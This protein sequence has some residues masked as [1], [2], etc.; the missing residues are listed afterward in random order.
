M[1]KFILTVLATLVGGNAAAEWVKIGETE[2]S[3]TYVEPTT[4]IRAG[5]LARMWRMVDLRKEFSIGTDKPFMSS[6]GQDEYD[7]KGE[8]ARV[9]TLS[10]HSENMGAGDVVHFEA[11]ATGWEPVKPRSIGEILWKI[12]CG[13]Q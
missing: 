7:C 9:I 12:G 8:K 10:F 1:R 3:A 6:K 5:D 11:N 2:S 4:I 13:K